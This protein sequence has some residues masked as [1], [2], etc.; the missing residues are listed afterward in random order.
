MFAD[1]RIF[2]SNCR[3]HKDKEPHFIDSQHE[4]LKKQEYGERLLNVG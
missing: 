3:T 4:S 2:D 1:I